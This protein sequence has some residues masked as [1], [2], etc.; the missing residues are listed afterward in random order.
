MTCCVDDITYRGLV[1]TGKEKYPFES[2]DWVELT[3]RLEIEKHK[4][5]RGPGPILH[6]LSVAPCDALPKDEQVAVFY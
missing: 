3:A 6:V 1:C 2:R 5:Y 4:L